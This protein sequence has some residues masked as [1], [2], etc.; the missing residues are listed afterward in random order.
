MQSSDI[1]ER[2]LSWG[3]CSTCGTVLRAA[4]GKLA[5]GRAPAVLWK[6]QQRMEEEAGSVHCQ[7]GEKALRQ[8]AV[9]KHVMKHNDKLQMQQPLFEAH[10]CRRDGRAPAAAP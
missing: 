10:C 2:C 5:A 9:I 1:S 4:A 8:H 7:S 6:R 3:I